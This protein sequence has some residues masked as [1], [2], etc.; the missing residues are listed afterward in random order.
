MAEN[1]SQSGAPVSEFASLNLGLHRAARRSTYTL[2]NGAHSGVYF[3]VTSYLMGLRDSE[4]Y[5]VDLAMERSGSELNDIVEKLRSICEANEIGRIAFIE[6][7]SERSDRHIARRDDLSQPDRPAKLRRPSSQA[8]Q[9]RADSGSAHIRR[10]G[11]PAGQRRGHDRADPDRSSPRS[12]G[13]QRQGRPCLR[14]LRS[15]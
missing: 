6:P 8:S 11:D 3:D 15:R 7:N 14:Y 2:N 9:D 10:R 13:R 12:P 5:E 4:E 1:S